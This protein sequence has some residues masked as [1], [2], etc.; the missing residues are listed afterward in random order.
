MIKALRKLANKLETLDCRFSKG[1][2]HFLDSRKRVV[3]SCKNC[4]CER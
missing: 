1:W 4:I 3:R 2:N